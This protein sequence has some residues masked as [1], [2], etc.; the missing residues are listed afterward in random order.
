MAPGILG[1]LSYRCGREGRALMNV[2]VVMVAIGV[3]GFLTTIATAWQGKFKF[4]AGAGL[5]TGAVLVVCMFV[6]R[7]GNEQP[8][9]VGGLQVGWESVLATA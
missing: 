1:L 7:P 9:A 4:A 5:L 3:I 2:E 6:F 8:A